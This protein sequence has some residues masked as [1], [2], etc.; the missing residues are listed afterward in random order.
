MKTSAHLSILAIL[1]ACTA[2][3]QAASTIQF[4]TTSY[5]VAEDAATVTLIVQRLDDTNTLVGVDYAST[6][7]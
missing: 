1:R 4:S 2:G 6:T 7:L 5:T 3:L